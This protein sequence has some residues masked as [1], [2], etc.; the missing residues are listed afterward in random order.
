MNMLWKMMEDALEDAM[1]DVIEDAGRYNGRRWKML[2]DAG[3]TMPKQTPEMQSQSQKGLMDALGHSLKLNDVC[4]D[5]E[6]D[7]KVDFPTK[8]MSVLGKPSQEE[9]KSSKIKFY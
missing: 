3:L 4:C 7:F 8:N 2:E 6:T 1:E 5:Q 9:D